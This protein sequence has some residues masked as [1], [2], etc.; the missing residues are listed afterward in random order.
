MKSKKLI[1]ASVVLICVVGVLFVFINK[2]SNSNIDDQ[3]NAIRNFYTSYA[4]KN[5]EL[6]NSSVV[7][8]LKTKNKEEI[9]LRESLYDDILEFNLIE[10]KEV[11]V[12]SLSFNGKTFDKSNIA[13][14]EVFYNVDFDKNI[15][16]SEEGKVSTLKVLTRENEDS[17][18][19]IAGQEGHGL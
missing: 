3:E 19:L 15:S 11:P 16:S 1:I 18:W 2:N 7:D 9:K 17:P 13:K 8:E 10:I 14:F 6:Y 12:N 5:I 4:S